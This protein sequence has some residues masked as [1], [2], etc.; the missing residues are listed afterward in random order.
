MPHASCLS[1]RRFRRQQSPV[2]SESSHPAPLRRRFLP[3]PAA[4]TVT[5][6]AGTAHRHDVPR[7][8]FPWIIRER[9]P[10]SRAI[11]REQMMLG[12]NQSAGWIMGLL[13][14]LYVLVAMQLGLPD[15]LLFAGAFA[16]GTILAWAMWWAAHR[17]IEEH[18]DSLGRQWTDAGLTRGRCPI[19]LYSLAG[20][21]TE[22]DLRCPE[23]GAIWHAHRL[24]NV[25]REPP[26]RWRQVLH[27]ALGST[28][29]RHLDDDLGRSFSAE[30]LAALLSA[31]TDSQ[32]R[33]HLRRVRAVGTLLRI[34]VAMAAAVFFA[35][36]LVALAQHA[37]RSPG[38]KLILALL[39]MAATLPFIIAAI[40]CSEFGIT[41]N[42]RRRR[43][44]AAGLCPICAGRDLAPHDLHPGHHHCARCSATWRLS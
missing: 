27:T 3:Q 44:L 9:D 40:W 26:P 16:T 29:T 20:A 39:I 28:A 10:A 1:S 19:C 35:F 8:W 34:G 7:I 42:A 18:W 11:R 4:L 32:V 15:Y 5:D 38:F 21:A 33:A 25:A 2:R 43:M 6:D 14:G 12:W 31:T 36:P 22:Q 37:I 30:K 24:G 13:A 23:C 41:A 17:H